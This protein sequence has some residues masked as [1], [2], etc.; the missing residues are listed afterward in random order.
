METVS[1]LEA[2]G[3]INY[4]IALQEKKSG[5]RQR[6]WHTH[7]G[8]VPSQNVGGIE[9]V[10]HPSVVHFVD[11]HE[12]LPRQAILRPS[13]CIRKPSLSVTAIL[14]HQQLATLS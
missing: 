9:F 7:G 10:V 8:E 5:K 3:R 13:L 12:F 14:Q 6:K 2:A 1:C 4:P 11:S